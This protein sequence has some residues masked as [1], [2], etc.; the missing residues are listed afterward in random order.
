MAREDGN[1]LLPSWASSSKAPARAHPVRRAP[2]PHAP[3]VF[4]PP[5]S[6]RPPVMSHRPHGARLGHVA[7]RGLAMA[8]TYNRDVMAEAPLV[9][10]IMGSKSDWETMRHADEMLTRLGVSHECAIVSAH[11]T[12]E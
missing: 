3:R 4:M 7:P 12:P 10:V 9:A 6:H 5:G 8:V 11:R 1:P 2:I